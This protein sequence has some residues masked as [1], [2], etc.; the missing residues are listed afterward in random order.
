MPSS[1]PQMVELTSRLPSKSAKIRALHDGGFSRSE[2]A[3]FLGIRYQ[4]VRNVLVDAER[5]RQGSAAHNVAVPS[6]QPAR[7]MN[8]YST[9]VQL[10]S[11]GRV[12]LPGHI[13]NQLS[14]KEGDTLIACLD[15]DE[16]HL[17]TIPAAVR[18]AQAIVRQ[19]V[20]E[21]VSLV[22][23]LLEERRQENEQEPQ[24]A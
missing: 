22:E 2:I 6:G 14:L 15:G 13:R 18:R 10:E 8:P 17:L 5:K 20:P 3:K 16:I 1:P 21:G 4:F 11:G 19:F 12:T 9:K 24:N 7:A 23:E